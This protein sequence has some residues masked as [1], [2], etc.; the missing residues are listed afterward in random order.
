MV[1]TMSELI[2]MLRNQRDTATKVSE[3]LGA[4]IGE[5]ERLTGY[6]PTAPALQHP[7]ES[8]EETVTPTNRPKRRM[9]AAARAKIAAAQRARWA[10][11]R[12]AA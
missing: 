7:V 9:S 5:L 12:K 11:A 3:T 6:Q 10:K 8:M 4:S 1:N 2:E